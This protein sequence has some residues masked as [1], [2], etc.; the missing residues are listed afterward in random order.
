MFGIDDTAALGPSIP[1]RTAD[2]LLQISIDDD[3]M[4][5]KCHAELLSI[6]KFSHIGRSAKIMVPL[7]VLCII[8]G[9]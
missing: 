8:R 6:R 4:S 9:D 1:N 5:Y 7:T 2:Q 3:C